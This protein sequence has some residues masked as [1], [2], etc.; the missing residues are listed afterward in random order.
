MGMEILKN[1]INRFQQLQGKGVGG[2][3]EEGA[4]MGGRRGRYLE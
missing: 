4:G 1:G 2:R 3:Q